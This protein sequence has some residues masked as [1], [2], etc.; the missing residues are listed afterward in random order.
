M[1]H[2]IALEG[3]LLLHVG[4]NIILGDLCMVLADLE[5]GKGLC[6]VAEAG[7]GSACSQGEPR[8]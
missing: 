4:R 3:V 5:V 2:H 8:F 6:H 1:L 7:E